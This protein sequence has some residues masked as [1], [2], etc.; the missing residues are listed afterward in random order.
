MWIPLVLAAALVP[1][2]VPITSRSPEAVKLYR[3]GREKALNFDDVQAAALFRKALAIDPDFA[4]AL[5]YLG[6][7][8]QGPE[9]LAMAERADV[10]DEKQ[11]LSE[12]EKLAIDV[13]LAERTGADEKVRKLKRELADLAPN[14]W[15][16]QFQLGV[17]SMYDHKS[18]AAILY[19]GKAL[20]LNPAA[21]EAYNYLGYVLVQ[22]GQVEDGIAKVK[23]FVE[24]KPQESNSWDSLGEVLLAAGKLDEAE[25]AFRK[26][27]QLAPDDWMSW[28]GVAYSRF[29][30]GDWTGGREICV[31]AEKYTT[32]PSDKLA[33]DLVLAWSFLAQGKA[34]EALRTIDAIEKEAQQKKNDFGW[35]W[36]A[37]ERA[38]L[39][40][41][42]HR[43][44]DAHKQLGV[45]AARGSSSKVSGEEKNRLRRSALMLEARIGSGPVAAQA[46]AQLQSEL[47]AAPSNADLRGLVRFAEGLVALARGQPQQA[48]ESLSKCPETLYACRLQ[49][50]AALAKTGAKAQ[51]DEALRKLADANIRDSL[52]R[53]EDPSYLYISAGLKGHGPANRSGT[54]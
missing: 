43:N 14:D 5:A 50:T 30:R 27:S 16:P 39:L 49:L 7:L 47:S 1:G 12:A 26:A 32:R 19:L 13:L 11:H 3:Q 22:Q 31:A 46:L 41:E 36:A 33:V 40:V 4:L 8:T 21:A 45:A 34:E 15:L 2:E 6:K 54:P 44:D 35:A 29:F 37:L 24:L 42:L 48:V 52:H 51:A 25:P 23:K 53:G 17:Q 28:M 10:L 9:G 20:K 18:Q 38:E